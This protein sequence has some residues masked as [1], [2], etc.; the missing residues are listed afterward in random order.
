MDI[1]KGTLILWTI[2]HCIVQV[3]EMCNRSICL[4][5]QS[6][7]FMAFVLSSS[8][9]LVAIMAA[10]LGFPPGQMVRHTINRH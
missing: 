8:S 10:Q 3:I 2:K 4:V 5:T 7:E 9:G 6:V 1:R